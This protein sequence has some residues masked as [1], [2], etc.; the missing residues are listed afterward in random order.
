MNY[1][2][3]DKNLD[4]AVELSNNCSLNLHYSC[5]DEIILVVDLCVALDVEVDVDDE[6]AFETHQFLVDDVDDFVDCLVSLDD[7]YQSKSSKIVDDIK[8]C[9]TKKAFEKFVELFVSMS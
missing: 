1:N 8:A 7:D 2:L 5:D 6:D 4:I 9:L 3:F